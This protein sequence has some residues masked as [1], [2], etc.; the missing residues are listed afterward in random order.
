MKTLILCLALLFSTAALADDVTF[1]WNPN[2]E[3]DIAGYRLHFGDVS[4]V[5]TRTVDCG[6]VTTFPVSLDWDRALQTGTERYVVVTAYNTF[7]LESLPSN[8]LDLGSR[9]SAPQNPRVT[10]D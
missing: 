3:P 6:N 9:P 10:L 2:P 4:G 1:A 8:E 5:Y 7:G